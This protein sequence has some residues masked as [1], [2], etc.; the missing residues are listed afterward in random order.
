MIWN[1]ILPTGDTLLFSNPKP[2]FLVASI[3]GMTHN[4]LINEL[5]PYPIKSY[6]ALLNSVEYIIGFFTYTLKREQLNACDDEFRTLLG[7]QLEC[8]SMYYD[9]Q[10]CHDGEY[11]LF[12]PP[13]DLLMP[14]SW[15]PS[16]IN[17]TNEE[18]SERLLRY[19]MN[20]L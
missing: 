6:P 2:P 1:H 13:S 12:C 10:L 9:N 15:R 14:V 4:D 5:Y 8:K 20:I 18:R 11:D 19:L 16:W 3:K 17:W 7:T